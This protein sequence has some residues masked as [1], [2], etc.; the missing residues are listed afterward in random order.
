MT[1]ARAFSA[2]PASELQESSG[3]GEE[4]FRRCRFTERLATQEGSRRTLLC[5]KQQPVSRQSIFRR[6]WG[7]SLIRLILVR[8]RLPK[9]SAERKRPR[10]GPA[11]HRH[12]TAIPENGQRHWSPTPG[13]ATGPALTMS[14]WPSY[15]EVTCPTLVECLKP[16]PGTPHFSQLRTTSAAATILRPFTAERKVGTLRS[17]WPTLRSPT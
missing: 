14:Q 6:S 13:H 4:L 17:L 10:L 15:L 7:A 16:P 12:F 5:S 2:R 1:P 3:E 8:G 9:S 11:L